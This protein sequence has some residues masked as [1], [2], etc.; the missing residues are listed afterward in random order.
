MCKEQRTHPPISLYRYCTDLQ[1][2]GSGILQRFS[3]FFPTRFA[4]GE[5]VD[6]ADD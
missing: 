5:L 3:A 4:D 6:A 2:T 1:G